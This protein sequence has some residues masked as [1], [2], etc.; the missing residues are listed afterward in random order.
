MREIEIQIIVF[1]IGILIFAFLFLHE[2]SLRSSMRIITT[3]F[4]NTKIVNWYDKT[5]NILY[6]KQVDPTGK[7]KWDV[8]C[9]IT[10]ASK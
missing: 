3:S 9:L 7:I 6:I 5:A 1:F 4:G 10:E 8:N 2:R